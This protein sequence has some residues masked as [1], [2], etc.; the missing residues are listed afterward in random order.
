MDKNACANNADPDQIPHNDWSTQFA[1]H[2]AVSR[3]V[4]R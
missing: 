1:T 2:S 3:P 4:N